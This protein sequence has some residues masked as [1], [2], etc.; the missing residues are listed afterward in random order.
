MED[1]RKKGQFLENGDHCEDTKTRV[2]DLTK[3][4]TNEIN[5]EL[6]GK[7]KKNL[8]FLK[9]VSIKTN[10]IFLKEVL[11]ILWHMQWRKLP[12]HQVK[13]LFYSIT[14][15]V[16]LLVGRAQEK[17][18]LCDSFNPKDGMMFLKIKVLDVR[19]LHFL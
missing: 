6:P 16:P 12:T 5:N 19:F 15:L 7:Y 8:C 14:Y 1:I 4:N 18:Q 9:I 3:E 13:T 17:Q 2:M 10:G 11:I